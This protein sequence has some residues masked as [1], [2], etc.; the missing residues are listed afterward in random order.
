M[1]KVKRALSLL[2]AVVMAVGVMTQSVFAASNV[3]VD[4]GGSSKNHVWTTINID[5]GS[6]KW[7]QSK[8]SL[9]FTQTKGEIG[10]AT[11]KGSEYAQKIELYGAYT[12]RVDNLDDDQGA[13]EYYWKYKK[14]YTLKLESDTSY[15]IQIRPYWPATIGNEKGGNA[16]IRFYKAV[17]SYHESYW[18]WIDA[19]Q[20]SVKSTNKVS[21]CVVS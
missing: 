5:T 10:Y 13:K 15:S 2:L 21:T 7:Y 6:K 11:V 12:I 20:W 8:N 9:T 19:P 14:N 17:K 1:K 18:E 16:A 3:C 4:V